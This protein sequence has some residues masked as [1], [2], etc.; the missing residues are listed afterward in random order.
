MTT[1]ANKLKQYKALRQ[2]CTN[3]VSELREFAD[4]ASADAGFAI[5]FKILYQQLEGIQ[6]EFKKHHQTV[7]SLV[8]TLDEADIE[9]EEVIRKQFEFNSSYVYAVYYTLFEREQE[10]NT[11]NSTAPVSNNKPNVKLPRIEIPKFSALKNMEFPTDEWDFILFYMFSKHLDSDTMTRFELEHPDSS[12]VPTFESLKCFVLKQ[13]NALDTIDFSNTKVQ[14]PSDISPN[15]QEIHKIQAPTNTASSM[16]SQPSTSQCSPGNF[17]GVGSTRTN[18]LLSTAV[19]EILDIRGHYQQ[20]RVLLDSGSQTSYISQ[21]LFKKLG[22]HRFNFSTSIQGLSS[23]KE[24]TSNGGVT[25]SVKP[26]GDSGPVLN[27]DAI[28]LP[29][30]CADMPT[31][32]FNSEQYPHIHNLKLADPLFCQPGTIDV[33]LGADVFPYILKPGSINGNPNEPVAINTIFGYVIM[34][35][36]LNNISNNNAVSLFS[37]LDNDVLAINNSIKS[38]WELEEIPTLQFLSAEDEFCEKL[39]KETHIRDENGRY[40]V[41]L[42]FKSEP[43]F[44]T[45]SSRKM[46]LRRFHSLEKRLLTNP[47]LYKKY[48][49]YI[50]DYIDNDYLELISENSRPANCFYIPHHVVSKSDKIRIVYDASAKTEQN[51]SLNDTLLVG[52]KLQKDIVTILLHFRVH[53]VAFTCDIKGMFTQIVVDKQHTDFQRILWRFSPLE[54]INDYRL[55]RVTFGLSCSPFLANRT[56]MQLA[57]DEKINFPYAVNVLKNDIYVDD[58]ITSCNSLQ[59]AKILRDQLMAWT[60]STIS[61]TWIKAPPYRWKTF[62]SNRVARIQSKVNPSIWRHINSEFNPADCASRGLLP[63]ELLHTGHW[64]AGPPWL[65]CSE[66]S[67]PTSSFN[68]LIDSPEVTAEEKSV[69]LAAFLS[70]NVLDLLVEKY[71]TLPK[72]KRI[73]AWAM[74]FIH[75]CKNPFNRKSES[76]DVF[77]KPTFLTTKN[78]PL[79][80]HEIIV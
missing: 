69:T 68:H 22:L 23:M 73:V 9:S 45:E 13:C 37:M 78:F 33:L 18:V 65:K 7:L 70:E 50:R 15:S 51:I 44:D 60:D 27:V 16:M 6:N 56:I 3:Q 76:V 58:V 43:Q 39:F 10:P 12:Q 59:E 28:I 62:I 17:C 74:R 5:Q 4:R 1:A 48:S 52:P 79:S 2:M 63:S 71:S 21:K 72:L 55:K 77:L 80:C 19:V 36:I 64:W 57:H 32:Y 54:P 14:R 53:A 75:N 31:A 42:P 35:K 46:A 66:E 34:G 25:C 30:L 47:E 41:Q 61:L 29:K 38:F 8:A 26:V 11:S 20:A 40:I 24:I 67:W 49:E